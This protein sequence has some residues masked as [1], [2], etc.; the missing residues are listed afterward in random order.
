MARLRIALLTGL[1]L[2]TGLLAAQDTDDKK[3]DP[4]PAGTWKVFMPAVR[5]AAGRPVLLLKLTGKDDKWTGEVLDHALGGKCSLEKVSVKN[6]A[7][8]FTVKHPAL[9]LVCT[10]KLPAETKGPKL[11]G[12]ASV[13]QSTMPIELERSS[14]T[15]LDAFEQSREA[16]AREQP[17]FNA[18]NL[19]MTLISQAE[20]KKAKPAE[21]RSWAEKAVKSADLYGPGMQRNILLQVAE[22]LG[23]QKGLEAVALQYARRAER[24]L[25]EKE[26]PAA[27]KRVLSVLADVLEQAGKA[28]E[29]KMIR[30][31]LLKLDFRIKPKTYAG[32]KFK[33]NRVVLAELFTGSQTSVTAA[34]EMAAAALLKTFKPSELA[35]I[36]YHLHLEQP[37][38]LA[39]KDGVQRPRFYGEVLQTP[40]A[41]IINGRLAVR[42]R[43]GPED[44]QE[45]YDE[46]LSQIEP[47][48]EEDAKA[49]LRLTATRKGDKVSVTAEASKVD[50]T[51][52][53]RLRVV[54]V[55]PTVSYKGANG[56]PV[57][58]NVARAMLGGVDGTV[59]KGKTL[60]KTFTVDLA[61]LR[62]TL[63]A[64][65]DKVKE[66]ND[67]P[68]K[69]RPMEMKQLRVIAFV[70]NEDK[71]VVLQAAQVDVKSE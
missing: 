18:I 64:Y 25:D 16:L 48:L 9:P 56:Q 14:L 61:E 45:A 22:L 55:E 11:Y 3:P 15:S 60:K 68:D 49:E 31:K 57:H 62:K 32:R 58:H 6:K 12:E 42:S 30:A 21:V 51:A 71:G 50:D 69:R 39:C 2:A 1:V 67:F 24:Q 28:D 35:L 23:E 20:K 65:L 63:N 13:R 47:Q 37:D 53:Y 52:D 54:L 70:Q 44:A 43:G 59:I 66:S 8:H 29:A 46:Y 27:Q 40:P 4:P 17:G 10:V 7:L 33:S 5:D 38:P 36:E 19:A 26:G 34:P 41:L